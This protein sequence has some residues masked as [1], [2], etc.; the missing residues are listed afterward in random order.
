MDSFDVRPYLVSIQEMEFFEEEAEQ[1]ADNL[2][3]MLYAIC[4]ET[5][6]SEYW[7]S[8]NIAQLVVEITDMWLREPGLLESEV[9]ELE[10]YITH[11]VHRIEQDDDHNEQL[12]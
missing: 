9:D 11:L 5:M 4:N 10:D 7:Q 1:A 6:D 8:E 12:D 3:A 2:N